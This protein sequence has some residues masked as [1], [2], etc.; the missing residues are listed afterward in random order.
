MA[1]YCLHCGEPSPQDADFC[2]V[3]CKTVYRLLKNSDLESLLPIKSGSRESARFSDLRFLNGLIQND[4]K[5]RLYVEGVYCQS[6][7]QILESL[8]TW[9]DGIEYAYLNLGTRVLEVKVSE[10]TALRTFVEAIQALGYSVTPIQKENDQ[11]KCL[12]RDER[13]L[14]SQLGVA[15]VCTGNIM[16]LS[17]SEYS[18]VEQELL[19]FFRWVSAALFA[20]IL[21][22]SMKTVL[23]SASR[24]IFQKNVSIDS[25]LSASLLIGVA[26]SYWHAVKG[27]GSLYFDSLGAVVSLV[28]ASRYLFF[29]IQSRFL[30]GGELIRLLSA[31]SVQV[32]RNSNWETCDG[33][34][35]QRGDRIR[36]GEG[37]RIPVDG[38]LLAA[39]RLDLSAQNGESDPVEKVVGDTVLAGSIALEAVELVAT[40]QVETSEL[41]QTLISASGIRS[42]RSSQVSMTDWVGQLFFV[43]FAI[44]SLYFLGI[45]LEFESVLE[46]WLALS[47]ITCPCAV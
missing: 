12:K 38:Q 32:F 15:V 16:L 7:I 33:D 24:A 35:V 31:S 30:K 34:S 41:G 39:A 43:L 29:R 26:I 36:V 37:V 47:V 9:I 1:N 4:G 11:L 5:V 23:V 18:G 17:F 14:L 44:A 27:V 21:F 46:R 6:C 42:R 25:A 20:P 22:Y 3:G 8:P 40:T 10:K 45:G 2:C 19:Q 28:L 13:K